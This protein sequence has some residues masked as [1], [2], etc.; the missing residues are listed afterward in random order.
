M[1]QPL[2]NLISRDIAFPAARLD[3]LINGCPYRYK[4]YKIPKKGGKSK[5]TI[6]QPAKEVKMLQYWVIK[7]I[8]KHFKIHSSAT[9]YTPGK[10]I[11]DNAK[12]HAKN[13]FLLKLDF[14][15][16]FPSISGDDF[17][18]LLNDFPVDQFCDDDII[19]L[20]KILFWKP[21][22]NSGLCLSIGAPSSPFLSNA[23]M[24]NFDKIMHEYCLSNSIAYTRYADDLTFSMQNKGSRAHIFEEV[25]ATLS[26]INYPT[27][28]INTEKTVFGSRASKR[29]ITGV[30]LSNSGNISLGRARKRLIR[31]QL[32]HLS[33]EKL[34]N[35]EINSLRGMIAFARDIEPSFISRMEKKY[36]LQVFALL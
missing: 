10:G 12:P 34:S 13:P 15:N 25:R 2:I 3:A 8:F 31:A 6:A 27:L 4:V 24:Y 22:R 11:K 7:N 17:I 16:F 21:A 5:R 9:A 20:K 19:K 29:F 14:K 30:V 35:E 36:G 26:R 1:S 28:Q 23:I 33:L 18:K 32:H